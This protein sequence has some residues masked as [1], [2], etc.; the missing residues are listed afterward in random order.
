MFETAAKGRKRRN[1]PTALSPPHEKSFRLFLHCGKDCKAGT[2]MKAIL[3]E[4]IHG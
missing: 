4:T 1:V 3:R 2:G